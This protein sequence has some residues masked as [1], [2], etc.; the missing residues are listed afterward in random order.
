MKDEQLKVVIIGGGPAAVEAAK[1][2]LLYSDNIKVI[3]NSQI[4]NWSKLGWSA[5]IIELCHEQ[6]EWKDL[7][8]KTEQKLEV[9]ANNI[10]NYFTEKKIETIIG[11]VN[12][13]NPKNVVV[14]TDFGEE[15]FP[16][17]KL[18]IAV[19]SSPFFPKEFQPDEQFIFTPKSIM[20]L[21]EL[22]NSILLIGNGPISY[23]YA[24]IFNYFGVHIKWLVPEEGPFT[25]I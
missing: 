15:I 5:G 9:W 2:V 16:Y 6:L 11:H 4:G 19:G 17:D 12:Q 7:L 20:S 25:Q 1:T 10:E 23:E 18:F 24:S 14:H 22:P 8:H 21:K 13:V 3:S